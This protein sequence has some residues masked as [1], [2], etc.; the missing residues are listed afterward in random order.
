MLWRA[1]VWPQERSK[2]MLELECAECGDDPFRRTCDYREKT[3]GLSES[4]SIA[5]VRRSL[6][7]AVASPQ[8][9]WVRNSGWHIDLTQAGRVEVDGAMAPSLG[10]SRPALHR[11]QNFCPCGPTILSFHGQGP[12]HA[13]LIVES[14][15]QHQR[16]D[17]SETSR[18]YPR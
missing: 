18:T 3:A 1:S 14:P 15:G 5:S 10:A 17:A 16:C 6:L 13:G 7:C 2:S 4:K 8:P 11:R 12:S 9:T